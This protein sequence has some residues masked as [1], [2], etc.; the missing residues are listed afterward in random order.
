MAAVMACIEVSTNDTLHDVKRAARETGDEELI[1]EVRYYQRIVRSMR[2]DHGSNRRGRER[3][4]AK[5]NAVQL[6]KGKG[7]R[8]A[9][10][11]LRRPRV[12]EKDR[13]QP[14]AGRKEEGTGVE[15]SPAG[16]PLSAA[17]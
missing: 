2:S 14:Q 16:E 17:E 11:N 7:G 6:A 3:R 10:K 9:K 5:R 8:Q 12:E 13:L 4:R 15:A 1:E